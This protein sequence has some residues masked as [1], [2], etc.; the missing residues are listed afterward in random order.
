MKIESLKTKALIMLVAVM[1]IA[2]SMAGVVFYSLQQA[3]D[4]ADVINAA[5]RQRMLSQAMAKSVLGY[6]M[7]RVS[8]ESTKASVADMDI[9]M[10]QMRSAYTSA[11][12]GPAKKADMI[13]SMNPESGI[14]PAVPYP[15]TFARQVNEKYAKTANLQADIISE[16]PINPKQNLKDATD[17]E[18]NIALAT[19]PKEMFFK[20]VEENNT[21][22]LR[23]YTADIATVEGCASCHTKMT[24]QDVKVGDMLG[25][26]R[27]SIKFDSNVARGWQRLN[28]SLEEFEAASTIFKE[29]LE[30]FKSGGDYPVD[31]KMSR[32]NYF[33]GSPDPIFQKKIVEIEAEFQIFNQ[34]VDELKHAIPGS[35]EHSAAQLR[36]IDNSNLLRK[37][38]NELTVMYTEGAN[39]NM[40]SIVGAVILWLILMLVVFIGLYLFLN[41]NIINPLKKIARHVNDMSEGDLTQTIDIQRSDELGELVTA[42]NS[43]IIDIGFSVD[44]IKSSSTYLT[45]LS[46]E[47]LDA[48]RTTGDRVRNQAADIEQAAAA[49]TEM[50]ITIDEMAGN[51]SRASD[52]TTKAQTSA[53][54]GQQ[55]V[56][57]TIN[58][59]AALSEEVKHAAEVIKRV[60]DDSSNINLILDTI[61]NIAEQTNLL[62]LNAAIEAARAGEHG[63]GFAVVADEVRSLASRTQESTQEIQEM[64]ERLQKGTSEAVNVMISGKETA[65]S[66][67]NQAGQTSEALQEIVNSV[68]VITD[69]NHQIATAAEGMSNVSSEINRNMVAVHEV[70]QDTALAADGAFESSYRVSALS[71]EV[72]SLMNRFMVDEA[73][74]NR[75]DESRHKLFTWD[76]SLEMGVEEIDRQ[77]KMLV[78]IINELYDLIQNK[79]SQR[80]MR[81]VLNGLVDYTLMH[82]SYE[83]HLMQKS[84]YPDF[85]NHV[86]LHKALVAQV[87]GFVGRVDAGEAIGDELLE[88]LKAW[89]VKHIK[90]QDKQYVPYMR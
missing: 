2:T 7:A 85:D 69:M 59:I 80:V 16:N 70:S 24:G 72:R 54:H 61:R 33:S 81:R 36:L 29:T 86:K 48:N 82:F 73:N 64:I 3:V 14:H 6:N 68:G 35:S 83:E 66:S 39:G 4:D 57:A 90:G 51:A 30:A 8:L 76:R 26:R 71:S 23:F 10:T 34:I 56:N 78:A 87:T 41:R 88:F 15:A 67:V 19:N 55:V 42:F 40:S 13:I 28:P 9:F 63:R 84:G 32:Y 62:A 58:T 50:S 21:L 1:L 60:E 46:S 18:A 44:S 38:S 31:L 5:G 53:N 25:I 52:A 45:N 65:E 75:A 37:L 74:L 47:M 49:V 27:F 12:I 79:R 11:V 43:A 22:Y 20:A 89:L 77:H 17:R